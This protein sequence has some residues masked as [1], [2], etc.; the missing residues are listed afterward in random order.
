MSRKITI[1]I[2]IITLSL[3]K[4]SYCHK[5]DINAQSAILIDAQSKRVL[6]S[7]NPH[8]KLP[9]AST[10]KIMTALLALENGELYDKIN[11]DINAVGIEGSSI[12]LEE[13]E[14]I[15]LE[16]LLYGLM[17]RSG[18]DS[19]VAI[20][21]YLGKNIEDF[22]KMMNE[23]AKNIG[24]E[25]TNFMNPH[26]LHHENHY[27]TAY[28]L[29]LI[30]AEAMNFEEFNQIVSSKT[31]KANRDKNNIFYNK[32]KTLWEYKGGD[33]VKTGY[34]TKSGRCLVTSA[35]RNGTKLIAV[36]LNDSN[37]FDDCYRLMDYGFD[38]FTTYVIYDKNQFMKEIPVTNGSKDY[39]HAVSKNSF[40]YP[41]S[42]EELDEVKI[43][44]N[45]PKTLEAPIDKDE[46]IGDITV[47]LEGKIIHKGKI[48]SKEKVEKL[49]MIRKFIKKI[50]D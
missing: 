37:W 20:A 24:A 16:D 33:G 28:D 5:P 42:D 31:W 13:G 34:T 4:A 23:K 25:D 27:S 40:L 26:G 35:T 1:I 22:V 36:V 19:A 9:I 45:L 12:Y 43:N 6:A 18:N 17:L 10:T 48:V 7:Y 44:I 15:T 32:N 2:L 3:G 49:G 21:E 39:I 11:V 41:L 30:T 8:T 29:A 38:N 14:V 46:I 50:K 47:Y